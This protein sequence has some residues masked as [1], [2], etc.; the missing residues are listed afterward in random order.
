MTSCEVKGSRYTCRIYSALMLV[1]FIMTCAVIFPAFSVEP[2]DGF[3]WKDNREKEGR[4]QGKDGLTTKEE[5]VLQHA[6]VLEPGEV[7]LGDPGDVIPVQIP[8][9]G[10]EKRRLDF[11]TS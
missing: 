8:A 10:D 7:H 2:F 3:D 1:C 4:L 9:R 11:Y 5:D 6:Q